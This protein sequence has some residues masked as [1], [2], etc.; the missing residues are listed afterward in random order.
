MLANRERWEKSDTRIADRKA[1]RVPNTKPAL[2]KEQMIGTYYSPL[3]GKIEVKHDGEFF[4][5]IYEHTPS[6]NCKLRHWH[7]DTWEIVWDVPQ[8]WFEHGTIRFNFDN[9]MKVLGIE[10]DVPNDDI[11]F[12]EIN[13]TKL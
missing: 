9:N 13:A 10:Y 5:V 11:F 7:H 4:S 12:E 1:A 2:S 3:Y 8:A 6:Y